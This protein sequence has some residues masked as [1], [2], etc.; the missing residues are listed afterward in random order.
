VANNYKRGHALLIG[1]LPGIG[2]LADAFPKIPYGRGGED[3]SGY[4]FPDYNKSVQ[5]VMA[6]LLAPY[7]KAP[8]V[9]CEIP[10]VEATLHRHR[11]T[12][13]YGVALVN[14]SGAPVDA[15][16]LV[17][18]PEALGDVRKVRAQYGTVKQHMDNGQL[19]VNLPLD[20]FDYLHLE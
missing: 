17:L 5:K 11:E 19:V 20:K 13:A 12:G 3:L 6:S 10:M 18:T 8:P 16:R 9:R 4:I 15:L 1:T 7:L 2:W 14:F